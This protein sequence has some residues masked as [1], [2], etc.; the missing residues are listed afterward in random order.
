MTLDQA[1]DLDVGPT[2]TPAARLD[3]SSM[4]GQGVVK[5]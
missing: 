3:D 1:A 4:D 5:L 2:S